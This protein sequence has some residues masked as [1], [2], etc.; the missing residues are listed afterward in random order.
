MASS[1]APFYDC[2]DIEDMEIGYIFHA[3]MVACGYNAST[4]QATVPVVVDTFFRHSDDSISMTIAPMENRLE[5]YGVPPIVDSV[6]YIVL[7]HGDPFDFILTNFSDSD[8]DEEYPP[9]DYDS[10][11]S[12]AARRPVAR[13]RSQARRLLGPRGGGH[14]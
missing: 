4:L 14:G 3:R 1:L 13:H 6:F 5:V 12:G 10:D 8:T 11:D 9:I 7:R 2:L